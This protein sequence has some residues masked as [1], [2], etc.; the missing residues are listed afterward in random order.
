MATETLQ[1]LAGIPPLDLIVHETVRIY[2]GAEKGAAQEDVLE[3]WKERCCRQ[4]GKLV[5]TKRLIGD[6]GRWIKKKHGRLNYYLV[7]LLT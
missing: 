7:Q 1:V 2:E 6:L 5:W 4:T 3:K